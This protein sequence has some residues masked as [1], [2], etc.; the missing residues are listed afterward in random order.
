MRPETRRADAVAEE[1]GVVAFAQDLA[2]AGAEHVQAGLGA[3]DDGGARVERPERRWKRTSAS[4][5]ESSRTR[6]PARRRNSSSAWVSTASGPKS[7]PESSSRM[8]SGRVAGG[9]RRRA[10]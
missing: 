1:A 2:E 5:A 10:E 3:A 4:P 9:A 7:V 8:P 6:S